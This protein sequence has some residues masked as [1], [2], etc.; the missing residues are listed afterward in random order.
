L[1]AAV[2]SE[3]SHFAFLVAHEA[4]H[5]EYINVIGRPRQPHK[6]PPIAPSSGA[7]GPTKI[8]KTTSN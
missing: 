1:G 5:S 8:V 7:N 2:K 6:V 4:P 3:R